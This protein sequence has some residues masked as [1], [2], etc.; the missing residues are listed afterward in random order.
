MQLSTSLRTLLLSFTFLTSMALCAQ[1]SWVP[2]E[3]LFLLEKD[4]TLAN[5][6]ERLKAMLPPDITAIRMSALYAGSR[7][8][9]LRFSGAHTSEDAL[10]QILA[11]IPGVSSTSLNHRL[12]H[13]AQPNDPQYG[14]QW[15]MASIGAEDLWDVTTGGAMA[16]GMRVAVGI[17]DEL[18]S[19]E[20][21]DLV[22]N[23]SSLS[24]HIGPGADHGTQVAGVVGAVGDNGIGIAGVNWDVDLLALGGFGDL[25]GAIEGFEAAIAL[26]EAFNASAGVN[27]ALVVAVTASWTLPGIDC[28]FG[29][30]ILEDLAAAGILIITAGDNA[31][32]DLDTAP[33]FPSSCISPSNIVVTSYGPSNEIPFAFG[34]NTVHLLA[35]GIDIPTTQPDDTYVLA[36]GNSFA[37]PH[38]AGA[39]ALLYAN[40]CAQFASFVLGD[41]AG[42]AQQVKEAILNTVTPVPGTAALTIT[43]GRL[44]VAAAY[45]FLTSGCPGLCTEVTFSASANGPG[46]TPQ[47][48]LVNGSNDV[49]DTGI[50]PS[51]TTCVPEGCYQVFVLDDVG[52]FTSGTYTV[53]DASGEVLDAGTYNAFIPYAS[54][55]VVAGCTDPG[56]INFDPNATCDDGSCCF[57]GATLTLTDSGG[58]GWGGATYA[59]MDIHG[60]I[61]VSG[62]LE[63]GSLGT[64][65]FCLENGCHTITV[66]AGTDPEE[67]GWSISGSATLSGGADG[68]VAFTAG[69]VVPGC[70]DPGASNFDPG[71]NCDDGSCCTLN[72]VELWVIPEEGTES[73]TFNYTVEAP[74]LTT[75]DEGSIAFDAQVGIFLGRVG[76][77]LPNGCT[78]VVV[79]P[80]DAPLLQAALILDQDPGDPSNVSALIG[81]TMYIGLG[82][83]EPEVCDGIDNDCDGIVDNDFVWYTDGD[84]DGF[85]AVGSEVVQC[86]QPPGTVAVGG[87]CNDSDPAIFPGA[88]E[89]CDGQDNDCN[90]VV[91][92]VDEDFQ[93]GCTDLLA[94]NYDPNAI[95]DDGSCEL[96]NQASG[97]EVYSPNWSS[98]G[99]NAEPVDVYALLAQG[100][101][102][103]LDLFTYW[104]TPSQLM[105]TSG[106]LEAWNDHLGP[107]G[108]DLIRMISVEVD[109]TTNP[110]LLA[111]YLAAADWPLVTTDG[112]SIADLYRDLGLYADAVPTILMI[113][114][115]RSV[116]ALYPTPNELPFNDLF[117]YD[118][119]RGLE[120]LGN[121]CR[122]HAVSCVANIGCMDPSA[123]NFDPTATCPSGDCITASIWFADTDG[124]GR[125]D[126][127][128]FV[129][130]C[131]APPGFVDNALDC[132]DDNAAIHLEAEDICDGLD[133][134]C[135]GVVDD[136]FAA[137]MACPP[138]EV[139]IATAPDCT[140]E[141][142]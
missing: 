58:D 15:S 60:S 104:C 62:T 13:L 78:E 35:P 2:G 12:R 70:T 47:Y 131:S 30:P 114:P 118:P 22:D 100:K 27:G 59:V 52:D 86:A 105:V 45:T 90:G 36:S 66:T 64:V 7:Y 112:P 133:N 113:C 53:T 24:P 54:F 42:A 106:F 19:T 141:I 69:I 120:V 107:D 139:L 142:L 81:E 8:H 87:D 21:P 46:I 124:D 23:I 14:D 56:A 94:C 77:C 125:G 55:G 37:I 26:R 67:I 10:A 138:G 84:G 6:E 49:V 116:T 51:F 96:N 25:G 39:V 92:G 115:D 128:N 85:G 136:G 72:Y 117:V 1:G 20:H 137:E 102:V 68:T 130:A 32:V 140:A 126:G 122:C 89:V 74:G 103:I 135:N 43:G 73:G 88:N 101:T 57:S 91:D 80:T 71:A 16:N 33:E 31:S 38:V 63:D 110:S 127:D 40:D 76:L 97:D 98:T 61:L 119:E 29:N 18:V 44:N 132:D 93:S 121:T 11:R 28:G 3:I 48:F 95:C 5:T 34:N 79:T 109:G 123:C 9:R 108:E 129:E 82:P 75:T 17:V 111:P 134:D 99:F 65:P 41:P 50:G 83:V 4:A